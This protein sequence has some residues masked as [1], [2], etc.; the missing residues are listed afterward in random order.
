MHEAVASDK[1]GCWWNP[2]S[3]LPPQLLPFLGSGKR[4][5]KCIIMSPTGNV[6]AHARWNDSLADRSVHFKPNGHCVVPSWKGR[7]VNGHSFW[8]RKVLSQSFKDSRIKMEI[9]IKRPFKFANCV[10]SGGFK[11]PLHHLCGW[12]LTRF[13]FKILQS[14][15]KTFKGGGAKTKC[16]SAGFKFL[17]FLFLLYFQVVKWVTHSSVH[18]RYQWSYRTA[19]GGPNKNINT[20]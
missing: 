7:E 13:G 16:I 12:Y 14:G 10:S 5:W 19:E 11:L 2:S 6:T 4:L 18:P 9:K 20:G 17:T 8:R 1:R 3:N 15:A